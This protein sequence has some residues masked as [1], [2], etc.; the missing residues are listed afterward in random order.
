MAAT[1]EVSTHGGHDPDVDRT[2]QYIVVA[3]V[4]AAL[5]ALEVSTYWWPKDF[6]VSLSTGMLVF[7]MIVK[8]GTVTAFFMHLKFDKRIL[9]IVFYS[10]LFLALGVYLAVL[11]AFRFWGPPD[12][13]VVP[14]TNQPAGQH[15]TPG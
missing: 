5:T 2:K 12:N 6:P 4:L 3:V 8:F 11:T 9:T 7:L 14:Q 1:T 13:H 10:G 15:S